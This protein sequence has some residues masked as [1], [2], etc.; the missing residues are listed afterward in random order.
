GTQLLFRD[1]NSLAANGNAR[2]SIE[3]AAGAEVWDVS[4]PAMPVKMSCITSGSSLGFTNTSAS[5]HEYCC[6]KQSFLLPTLLGKLS[7]QDIHAAAPAGMLIICYPPFLAQARRISDFHRQQDQLSSLVLTT[8]QVFNEFS[9]GSPDPVAIRNCMK[10]FYDRAGADSSLRPKY[11]LLLGDASFDYKDRLPN[12]TNFVPGYQNNASFDP[13]ASYTS[14]DFFGML[15]DSDDINAPN[16][17]NLLDIGIGRIPAR[18]VDEASAFVD[19]LLQ[20][21]DPKS[22]GAW[23][24]QLSFIADDQD[25]NLHL[26]D[27]EAVSAAASATNA[28]F[29]VN[30]FFLDAFK[31]EVSPF[32]KSY[33]MA[34]RVI[35][36]QLQTGNLIWNYSGHGSYSRLA[37]EGVLD[38]DIA[39]GLT[40]NY[41]LPL[42]IT[43]ACDFA[44]FDN[45]AIQSLGEDLLFQPNTGAI[46]LMTTTRLVYSYSNRIMNRNYLQAALQLKPDGSYPS[47]GEAVRQA[48]N[49]T[50]RTQYDITNNRKF[51][52]LGDPALTLS[53]PAYRV[54]TDSVNGLTLSAVPDTL[55]PLQTCSIAGSIR[56]TRGNIING[57]NGQVLMTVQDAPQTNRTLGNDADSYPQDFQV[58][59]NLLFKGKAQVINGRFSFSFLLPKDLHA[60]ALA[61]RISY[62]ADN[63]KEDANGMFNSFL[64]GGAPLPSS[65]NS[66]PVI[67]AYLNN[68]NFVDGQTVPAD[69]VLFLQLSDASGINIAG[70][71]S[72][73]GITV[74]IDGDASNTYL[75][76]NLYE[77]DSNT[78]QRGR[79]QWPLTGLEAG[80]HRLLITVWDANNNKTELTLH[81]RMLNKE[82]LAITKLFNYPNP[83]VNS[84]RFH[85]EYNR[86]DLRPELNIRIIS[87]FGQELKTIRATI[88][89]NGSRSSDIDWD[90][91][92][93]N[94]AMLPPGIYI[95]QLQLRSATDDQTSVKCGKLLR[96]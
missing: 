58:G 60:N 57:F 67:K 7:N 52:L 22:L 85:V 48:K 44:P 2:F 28:L 72:G 42:I 91:R 90:G 37:E 19:K 89:S 64:V 31:Q 45:P 80:E 39:N 75:L 13:V 16:A 25:A 68:Q 38:R 3:Q 95:Y 14:D 49:V 29:Q 82:K 70:T 15:D 11:L 40:N 47:L 84:T 5:L 33:P 63:G 55:Q 30:K 78:Y 54:E 66:G 86:G 26:N 69:P 43:A 71:G 12:N 73:K 79:L 35:N 10:M 74:V 50:Y 46:A 41:R 93:N 53:F 9:G 76:N 62:Y 1:W 20:Y 27:A 34:N 4:E 36:D 51:T 32:G 17:A 18:S 61:G 23:R 59:G 83:F 56:D 81:F 8:Q 6:F 21:K 24:N 94:G 87:L 65:D 77:A 96:L 88:N 92:G